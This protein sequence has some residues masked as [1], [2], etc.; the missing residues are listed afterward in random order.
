MYII[1]LLYSLYTVHYFILLYTTPQCINLR[2]L[3]LYIFNSLKAYISG[4]DESI[5]ILMDHLSVWHM[6]KVQE[7]S[8][9]ALVLAITGPT[10]TV[11]L[12]IVIAIVI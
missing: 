9:E 5:S 7:V 1:Y 12:V 3:I 2:I 10:G 11:V 6:S 4:Q 8:D